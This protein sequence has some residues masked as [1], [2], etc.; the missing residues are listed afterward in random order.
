MWQLSYYNCATSGTISGTMSVQGQFPGQFQTLWYIIL[1]GT[2]DLDRGPGGSPKT[3]SDPESTFSLPTMHFSKV[4]FP[5]PDGPT[6]KNVLVL[7][8]P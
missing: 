5:Q 8:K 6:K 2:P 3:F 1:P 7:F 4:V